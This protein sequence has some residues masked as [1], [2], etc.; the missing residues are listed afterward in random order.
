MPPSCGNSRICRLLPDLAVAGERSQHHQSA[1][2]ACSTDPQA[3]H[4][5]PPDQELTA[6]PILYPLRGIYKRF[7]QNLS[8]PRVLAWSVAWAAVLWVGA[9][10]VLLLLLGTDSGM[11]GLPVL[12]MLAVIAGIAERQSVRLFTHGGTS[13]D[14]SV[15]FL[16]FVFTAV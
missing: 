11:P 8:A 13:L 7:R 6:S 10:A 3:S 16:P 4:V 12:A 5:K 9:A 1:E 2:Q 15:S 14:M